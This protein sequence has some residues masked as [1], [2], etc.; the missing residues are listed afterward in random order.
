[1]RGGLTD[2]LLNT[3]AI[4]NVGDALSPALEYFVE[5]GKKSGTALY[6]KAKVNI[7]EAKSSGFKLFFMSETSDFDQIAQ[8]EA[9][10]TEAAQTQAAQAPELNNADV[11][12]LQTLRGTS[13]SSKPLKITDVFKFYND[14]KQKV[15]AKIATYTYGKIKELNAI[16]EEEA[17]KKYVRFPLIENDVNYITDQFYKKMFG[18]SVDIS[19][20]K[21]LSDGQKDDLFEKVKQTDVKSNDVIKNYGEL[22]KIKLELEGQISKSEFD[23]EMGKIKEIAKNEPGENVVTFDD[24]LDF[25]KK[26]NVIETTNSKRDESLI[27]DQAADVV[28]ASAPAPAAVPVVVPAPAPD[29]APAPAAVPVVVP[30]PAPAPDVV[31]TDVAAAP[32]TVVPSSIDTSSHEAPPPKEKIESVTGNYENSNVTQN[33]DIWTY[34]IK[35]SKIDSA[36]YDVDIKCPSVVNEYDVDTDK[37]NKCKADFKLQF[38]NLKLVGYSTPQSSNIKFLITET[39]LNNFTSNIVDKSTIWKVNNLDNKFVDIPGT[40]TM[41]QVTKKQP[42]AQEAV[43]PLSQFRPNLVSSAPKATQ[44]KVDEFNADMKKIRYDSKQKEEAVKKL[45]DKV[46]SILKLQNQNKEDDSDSDDDTDSENKYFTSLTN[47]IEKHK[48]ANAAL[49]ISSN[50]TTNDNKEKL[51]DHAA[52]LETASVIAASIAL[53]EISNSTSTEGNQSVEDA[54]ARIISAIKIIDY[55]N[56]LDDKNKLWE[57]YEIELNKRFETIISDKKNEG[58]RKPDDVALFNSKILKSQSETIQN[59]KE[60]FEKAVLRQNVSNDEKKSTED[61]STWL[62]SILGSIKKDDGYITQIVLNAFPRPPRPPPPPPEA[63]EISASPSPNVNEETLRKINEEISKYKNESLN[64]VLLFIENKKKYLNDVSNKEDLQLYGNQTDDNAKQYLKIMSEI[65]TTDMPDDDKTKLINRLDIITNALVVQTNN[66][67]HFSKQTNVTDFF[68]TKK[69]MFQTKLEQIKKT[70]EDELKTDNFLNNTY[71]T[72]F[73][74]IYG[75]AS[76]QSLSY[77][78]YFKI[79]NDYAAT[80]KSFK[81]INAMDDKVNDAKDSMST[82]SYNK[83][84]FD[85]KNLE[86]A[87]YRINLGKLTTDQRDYIND[88]DYA[89]KEFFFYYIIN[90]TKPIS[91]KPIS[92]NTIRLRIEMLDNMYADANPV[93]TG[94]LKEMQSEQQRLGE[95]NQNANMKANVD[96]IVRLANEA[97]EKNLPQVSDDSTG[98]TNASNPQTAISGQLTSNLQPKSSGQSTSNPQPASTLGTKTVS[99]LDE[100]DSGRQV[101]E[102]L[103]QMVIGLAQEIAKV[104]ERPEIV[105]TDPKYLTDAVE[106]ILKIPRNETS[107]T[108]DSI[109][110]KGL[111]NTSKVTNKEVGVSQTGTTDNGTNDKFQELSGKIDSLEKTMGK[112]P[113]SPDHGDSIK[114]LSEVIE[115]LRQDLETRQQQPVPSQPQQPLPPQMPSQQQQAQAQ[116]Q[117][118]NIG[119]SPMATVSSAPVS[120]ANTITVSPVITIGSDPSRQISQ[121]NLDYEPQLKLLQDQIKK[122]QDEKQRPELPADN[123]KQLQDRIDELTKQ[124]EAMRKQMDEQRGTLETLIVKHKQELE[125]SE[126][127]KRISIEEVT[128]NQQDER[129]RLD[130]EIKRLRQSGSE[131]DVQEQ[132][133][134]LTE[135]FEIRIKTQIDEQTTIRNTEITNKQQDF[136]NKFASEVATRNEEFEKRSRELEEK[137]KAA[138]AAI[139][140]AEAKISAAEAARLKA[141]ED[142]RLKAEQDARLKV[143][144][145]AKADVNVNLRG[146]TINLNDLLAKFNDLADKLKKPPGQGEV[147]QNNILIQ[148]LLTQ[149]KD[150]ISK[151]DSLTEQEKNKLKDI[152]EIQLS[153]CESTNCAELLKQLLAQI[154]ELKKALTVQVPSAPTPAPTPAPA[155]SD[156]TVQVPSAPAP[157]PAPAPVPAPVPAPAPSALSLDIDAIIAR[158]NA[159]STTVGDIDVTSLGSEIEGLIKIFGNLTVEQKKQALQTILLIITKLNQSQNKEI[160]GSVLI[161]LK[162]LFNG[163]N[164]SS[165]LNGGKE[166]LDKLLEELAKKQQRQPGSVGMKVNVAPLVAVEPQVQVT[167]ATEVTKSNDIIKPVDP[168]QYSDF[169][170]NVMN[171]LLNSLKGGAELH[172]ILQPVQNEQP[173]IFSNEMVTNFNTLISE[174]TNGKLIS[175]SIYSPAATVMPSELKETM[176]S[177]KSLINK[178]IYKSPVNLMLNSL[179][180]DAYK[181]IYSD[182]SAKDRQ[183]GKPLILKYLEEF[184]DFIFIDVSQLNQFMPLKCEDH[185]ITISSFE[186]ENFEH[187][188]YTFVC[189]NGLKQESDYLLVRK[190]C[191]EILKK[192]SSTNEVNTSRVKFCRENSFLKTINRFPSETI[193]SGT[194][195][196]ETT[197]SETTKICHIL[198]LIAFFTECINAG[199]FANTVDDTN[200]LYNFLYAFMNGRIHKLNNLLDA[201]VNICSQPNQFAELQQFLTGND[202]ILA[203]Y[204][205]AQNQDNMIT[206]LKL[207][208]KGDKNNFEYNK[209]RFDLMTDKQRNYLQVKYNDNNESYVGGDKPTYSNKYLLGRF[210][211]IYTLK[212][213]ATNLQI[214]NKEIAASMT[215]AKE[216]ILKG[217][218]VFLIGYG[219]SGAGKT[220]T[221]VYLN[222]PGVQEDQ[223]AGILIHLCNDFGTIGYTDLTVTTQEFFETT[224]ALGNCNVLDGVGNICQEQTFK[225][226]FENNEFNKIEGDTK[227]KFDYRKPGTSGDK[228]G[229]VLVYLIDADRFVKPTTNNPNSSRSHSLIYVTMTSPKYPE[230][231]D[232]TGNSKTLH[233][234]IGDFAGVE[235][236]FDCMKQGVLRDMLNMGSDP[237][238]LD[239]SLYL[240]EKSNGNDPAFTNISLKEANKALLDPTL[241]YRENGT[242]IKDIDDAINNAIDIITQ[243][244]GNLKT[245]NSYVIFSSKINVEYI[246]NLDDLTALDTALNT[247]LSALRGVSLLDKITSD[248]LASLKDPNLVGNLIEI[249][250]RIKSDPLITHISGDETSTANIIDK[251]YDTSSKII[252]YKHRLTSKTRQTWYSKVESGTSSFNTP[253]TAMYINSIRTCKN[254]NAEI[255]KTDAQLKPFK[256]K[257][258]RK[259]VKKNP[260]TKRKTTRKMRGGAQSASLVNALTQGPMVKQGIVPS[261][262]DYKNISNYMANK[263]LQDVF[264]LIASAKTY[265]DFKS[266]MGLYPISNLGKGTDKF[267]AKE[268][269]TIIQSIRTTYVARRTKIEE[270]LKKQLRINKRR[271]DLYE[272]L[273]KT[274]EGFKATSWVGEKQQPL[275]LKVIDEGIINDAKQKLEDAKKK[276]NQSQQVEPDTDEPDSEEEQVAT[277]VV[278]DDDANKRLQRKQLAAKAEEERLNQLLAGIVV[279]ID[280]TTRIVKNAKQICDERVSEGIFINRSLKELRENIFSIMI[281]KTKNCIYYSPPFNA[282][283]LDAFC[284]TGENCFSLRKN[285]GSPILSEPPSLIMKWIFNKYKTGSGGLTLT[286]FYKKI[287]IGVFCVLNV[288]PTANNPPPIPYIDINKLKLLWETNKD[289]IYT[290]ETAKQTSDELQT[291]I[292]QILARIKTKYDRKQIEMVVQYLENNQFYKVPFVLTTNETIDKE[293]INNMNKLIDTINNHNSITA[294]GTLEYLDSVA[295]LNTTNILCTDTDINT[296]FSLITSDITE[297]QEL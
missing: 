206:Y 260:K 275:K 270:K 169:Q 102:M 273:I 97:L 126:E 155:P 286:D 35:P 285:S 289:L 168:A 34:E 241:S 256:K 38:E 238:T 21:S 33:S 244:Y 90:S 72:L 16:L 257:G 53:E 83:F 170:N 227:T 272:K 246:T 27:V 109:F 248:K 122:L 1:M 195:S 178:V 29:P 148:E 31:V 145:D 108:S 15:N 98:P 9:A 197:P 87:F 230:S 190:P 6:D 224:N 194:T 222:A 49:A 47:L 258:G 237:N 144:Q 295:K 12:E 293:Y 78:E 296:N 121:M 213:R 163:L 143:E 111:F 70:I 156:T 101:R 14:R 252:G 262:T 226:T 28:A 135:D 114:K 48:I 184:A 202:S 254:I 297:A 105:E 193:S 229:E 65:K 245:T 64:S 20:I 287:L 100:T 141:E 259:T 17:V 45:N 127:D 134:R 196:S 68:N 39:E 63:S 2:G 30:A 154:D 150:L 62:E 288:S 86:N 132:I 234:F 75:G 261:A 36:K 94:V 225:F 165:D 112:L 185:K 233:F 278:V 11:K 50:A 124:Y 162:G 85:L 130:E 291:E 279:P 209:Y 107:I 176:K 42:T 255:L 67:N 24:F 140:A 216:K 58:N 174:P 149:I 173:R 106:A 41:K 240:P 74:G 116:Q 265:D 103:N 119:T 157:A 221:L 93:I 207:N 123:S 292:D 131:S 247:F 3:F 40:W 84:K 249:L 186:T 82:S 26:L 152:L 205:I 263:N 172:K 37:Y 223:R 264:N 18:P 118:F 161:Q 147:T 280:K 54:A 7:Y 250:K 96:E 211:K 91:A 77:D 57:K 95:N 129:S 61:C 115:K 218:P 142:A 235:N 46:S 201:Y 76:K 136:Q 139:A 251:I 208:N 215:V 232:G 10:Q 23:A 51:T 290:P 188:L 22:Y 294:V 120:P 117:T 180:Y 128:R 89:T 13:Y 220:S 79:I 276:I 25:F 189:T 284:P 181:N 59:I 179:D 73:S 214:T 277:T 177:F 80:L 71:S 55:E 281:E 210:D 192:I 175:E 182:A 203:K 219:A 125:K 4:K 133:R 69:K 151:K 92:E 266:L 81:E 113:T 199:D 44:E 200:G 267:N 271:I 171:G 253:E 239:K 66:A 243:A 52:T 32:P 269:S 236:M 228:L 167:S 159:L 88:L 104:I 5:K 137:L 146:S 164:V 110:S 242:L 56:C 274:A 8:T 231:S 183:T 187:Q 191:H 283:C 99:N 60:E 268:Y 19:R 153:D 204:V 212:N 160:Y 43:K 158:L 198:E 166:L 138:D 282:D 217:D